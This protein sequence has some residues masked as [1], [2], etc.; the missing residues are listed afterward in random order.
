MT[1]K[2]S[3][4]LLCCRWNDKLPVPA[5]H[6]LASLFDSLGV[7]MGV[8]GF[9]YT[10]D[11]SPFSFELDQ[12]MRELV[13]EGKLVESEG[14]IEVEPS[15]HEEFRRNKEQVLAAEAFIP[16]DYTS[17]IRDSDAV[18]SYPSPIALVADMQ[19]FIADDPKEYSVEEVKR[20]ITRR[21]NLKGVSEKMWLAA[22]HLADGF[23]F[24]DL[25]PNKKQREKLPTLPKPYDNS[26]I[27]VQLH[28]LSK[29][30]NFSFERV[31]RVGKSYCR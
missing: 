28:Y 14:K 23:G 27:N 19:R 30:R 31:S 20:T 4:F 12:A 16:W 26:T 1:P 3:L 29:A 5:V 2:E 10:P 15:V 21:L 18:R 17:F 11:I 9:D 22:Q 7:D 25:S 8:D 13:E 24:Y 6:S